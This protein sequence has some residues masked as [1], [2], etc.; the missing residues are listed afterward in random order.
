M[1]NLF[2]RSLILTRKQRALKNPVEG[3][4]FLLR[5]AC[6][7]L[8]DRLSLIDR[9]FDHAVTLFCNGNAAAQ[10]LHR[11]G[12]AR[13]ITVVETHEAF[14]GT[15]PGIVETQEIVPLKPASADLIVSLFA[16]HEINDVPGLLIQIRRALK[17]DGLFLAAFCGAGTLGELRDSFLVAETGLSGGAAARIY[18]F[19][20]VREAGALLQRAEFSLPVTDIETAK[21]RYDTPIGL[22]HDLRAMG[23]TNALAGRTR[24]PISRTLLQ[25]MMRHYAD[26]YSDDDG[27][28][29][30]TFN[31]IWLSGWAPHPSQQKPLKPGSATTNL[32][33][34][35]AEIGKAQDGS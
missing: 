9:T 21:V 5:R 4:D 2:D 13:R 25:Q 24:N 12:K 22:M 14:F 32:G 19:M 35:L 3:S 34:V 33:E 28:I 16:L 11:C 30:V 27:R 8:A 29:R 26:S 6:E 15:A 18:P 31:V 17:P 20:D 10:V 1:D 7:D 23:A